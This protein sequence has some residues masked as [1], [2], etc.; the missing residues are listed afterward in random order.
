MVEACLS[1]E[2]MGVVMRPVAGSHGR[3]W[4]HPDALSHPL[5]EEEVAEGVM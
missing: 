1:V 4:D 3:V 2:G 5:V